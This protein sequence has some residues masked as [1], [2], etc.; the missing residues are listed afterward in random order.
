MKEK[1]SAYAER[2]D[3]IGEGDSIFRDAFQGRV[4]EQKI[5]EPIETQG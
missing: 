2:N 5:C 4:A 3:E 1:G